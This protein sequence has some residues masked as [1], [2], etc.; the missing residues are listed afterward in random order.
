MLKV[1]LLWHN[2][3]V[4]SCSCFYFRELLNSPSKCICCCP[5]VTVP[6]NSLFSVF[7]IVPHMKLYVRSREKFFGMCVSHITFHFLNQS[8]SK[9]FWVTQNLHPSEVHKNPIS[10]RFHF[11]HETFIQLYLAFWF[12]M[13]F[14]ALVPFA[15][16]HSSA[17][18]RSTL[19]FSKHHI[20]KG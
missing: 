16:R 18:T 15:W 13:C 6:E 17:I 12:Q 14:R 9:V 10:R 3:C 1:H 8:E 11:P 7:I 2:W 4:L 20:Q 19:R 5:A